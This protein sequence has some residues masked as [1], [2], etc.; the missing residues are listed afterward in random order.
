MMKKIDPT[1]DL[2]NEKM[3]ISFLISND[4]MNDEKNR[5]IVLDQNSFLKYKTTQQKATETT[6]RKNWKK[7]SVFVVQP[8]KPPK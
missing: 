8:E 5:Q 7:Q 1:K 6:L 4:V 2:I 3:T